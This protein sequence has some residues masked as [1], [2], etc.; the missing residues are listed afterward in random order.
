MDLKGKA[1]V[2]TGSS[3]GA[4]RATALALAKQGCDV[5]IN[6]SSSQ[7]AAEKVV[8][9]IKSL[10]VN[11]IPF[12]AD[13]SNDDDC[14]TMMDTAYQAFGRLDILVNNAG[15]TE[16]IAHSNL[17]KATDE[18]WDKILGVNLKGPFHCIRAA[19]KYLRESGD[20]AIVNVASVAGVAGL[21]SSV[22]YCASKA[23]LINLGITM[24]RALGP[25][26]RVNTVS[27]GFIDGEWL[28][29]GFGDKYDAIKSNNE[30]KAVLNKV[31]QPEDVADA[32]LSLITG[33]SLVTGQNIICDGG[34][35]IG[36]RL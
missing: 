4:G 22:P 35:L 23:A 32:V 13:V 31:C 1:A 29:A 2:V 25:E 5:L 6:Y 15:T 33:S 17:E 27:P 20:A 7:D 12:R 19:E 34:M 30:K 9:E 8:E 26:I 11:S 16:F 3:R 18:I 14:R 21:G 28:R 24:A 10:G 36:P